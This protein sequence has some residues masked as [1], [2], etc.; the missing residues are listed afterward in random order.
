MAT[1]IH[2]LFFAAHPDPAVLEAI[3][4]AATGLR[5]AKLIRGRW[6]QSAKYH[7]TLRFLGDFREDAMEV[8]ARARAAAELLRP[9][10]FEIVLD[11]VTTFRGRFQSPCVLRCAPAAEPAVRTVWDGLGEALAKAG[12]DY[13]IDNRFIPHLTIAYGDRMLT[14]PIAIEP[15]AWRVEEFTLIDSHR[16]HYDVQARWPLSR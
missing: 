13:R 9:E 6:T 11:R 16:S 10:P 14:E 12:V 4:K 1:E 7:M 3:G 8:I 15:I 5:D 2:R